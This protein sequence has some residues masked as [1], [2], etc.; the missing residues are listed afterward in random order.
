VAF[1]TG[2]V[3]VARKINKDFIRE[4]FNSGI[5]RVLKGSRSELIMERPCKMNG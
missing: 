1:V 5:E 3:G 4:V 2:E